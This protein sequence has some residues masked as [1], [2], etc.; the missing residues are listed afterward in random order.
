MK[1]GPYK[2]AYWSPSEPE[3]LYSKMFDD[4]D[5]AKSFGAGL[6][7]EGYIHTL[8]KIRVIANG[9]YTWEI[10]EDEFGVWR[11]RS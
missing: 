11:S 4:R 1:I 7:E 3:I 6:E 5:V 9:H 10:L 8:M 2:V